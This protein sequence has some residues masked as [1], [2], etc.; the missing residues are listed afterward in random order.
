MSSPDPESKKG[1][2]QQKNWGQ[3]VFSSKKAKCPNVPEKTP[4]APNVTPGQ[5]TN[6]CPKSQV[7]TPYIIKG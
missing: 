6:N 7:T 5:L 2:G 1:K 3:I 4:N